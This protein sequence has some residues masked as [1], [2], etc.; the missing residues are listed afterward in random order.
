[1]LRRLAERVGFRS[2]AV[3]AIDSLSPVKKRWRGSL[4]TPLSLLQMAG[5]LASSAG[6]ST[7]GRQLEAPGEL[8]GFGLAP[9]A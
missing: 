4:T 5:R 2:T 6:C 7:S 1:M 9:A 3:Y 8:Q